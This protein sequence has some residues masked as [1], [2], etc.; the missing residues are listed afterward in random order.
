MNRKKSFKNHRTGSLFSRS[1]FTIL[2]AFLMAFT[3]VA[4]SIPAQ[5]ASGNMQITPIDYGSADNV[6]GDST[7]VSSGGKN[8]LMDTFIRDRYDTLINYLDDHHFYTFDIYLS[9]Y[10]WDHMDQISTI[11]ADSRFNVS[12]VYLPDPAYLRKGAQSSNYCQDLLDGHDDIVN[13]ANRCGCQVVYLKKGSSFTIGN[14]TANVLWGCSYSSSNYDAAYINNNSLVTKI[15]SGTVSYLTC[16]DIERE[17]ENQIVG[18]GINISADIFKFNHHGGNSSNT[19]A[20]VKK[21]NPSFAFEN[22]MEEDPSSFGGG[23]VQTAIDNLKNT[24]NIYSTRYNGML[25][26][27]VKAGHISVAGE[28]NM[29]SVNV[30]ITDASGNVVNTVNYQF[31]NALDYHITS[32]MK[33]T[34]ASVAADDAATALPERYASV[35]KF[36]ETSGGVK[37]RNKDGSYSTNKFQDIYGDTYYFDENGYRVTGFREINGK[38]YYFDSEGK[39]LLRWKRI[40]GKK[41]LFDPSDGHMHTGWEWVSEK[42]A[43]YYLSPDTGY[44]LEG[45]QFIGGKWYYLTPVDYYA[46]TG[47]QLIGGKWYFFDKSG[48]DMKTGWLTDGG[49]T[50]YLNKDG[51]M[52]TGT[53]NIDGRTYTFNSSG[54]L[55]GQAPSTASGSGT[56][57][58]TSSSGASG[59][60]T[61]WV[62][63]DGKWYYLQNGSQLKGCFRKIDGKTYYF[64]ENG[65]MLTGFSKIG[66]K[67]YYFDNSGSMLVGWKRIDGK[68]YFFDQTDGHMHTGWKWVSENST[69][70]YLSPDNGYLLEGWLDYGGKKYYLA[71]VDFYAMTGW[72]F[73]DGNWYYFDK[74]NADMK[75]GWLSDGGKTYYLN[76]D[77]VMVTGTQ[78]IDGRTY[79]F[80]SS[81]ALVG[82]AS[83]GSGTSA[84]TSSSSASGTT[85][86][87]VLTD[88]KWYY[89]QNGSQLKECFSKIGGKTYYFDENGVMLTG[90]GKIGGKT[91]CFDSSGS[92]LLG[93]KVIDGKKYF[94]DQTDGH[95]HTGW[96]WVSE[97]SAWYYLSPDYGYLLEGWLDYGGKKYYLTPADYDAKTGWQFIEGKWYF[98]DKTGCDMKTGWLSDGGKT[99]YL[100]EDGAMVTGSQTIDGKTYTFN[101]SGAMVGQTSSSAGTGLSGSYGNTTG[102]VLEDG[103]WF[104]LQNGAPIKNCFKKLGDSTYYLDENGVM[105]TGF[106][107]IG[108]KT[109]CFDTSGNMMLRWKR[110]DGKKYFFDPI[111]G[112]MHTGWEWVEE[113]KAWYYL[114]PDTGNLLEGWLTEGGRKYYLAPEEYYA[115]TGWQYIDDNWY[116]FDKTNAYMKTGWISDWGNS[117]YLREDGVMVTG[118]QTIEGETYTF[119]GSGALVGQ[120]PSGS[121]SSGNEDAVAGVSGKTLWN[122]ENYATSYVTGTWAASTDDDMPLDYTTKRNAAFVNTMLS[123]ATYFVDKIDYASSVTDNDPTGLRFLR[124]KSGGKTDCSW[125][126]YH[127]LYK[128]GL[129]GERFIHSY[130]WGNDPST[131]PGAVNIGTDMSKA[132]PGDIICTGRGTQSSNSHVMLYL[133]GNKVVECAAGYGVIIST[134]P[135]SPRQI[136]HFKC[137]PVNTSAPYKATTYGSWETSGSSWKFKVGGT[138]LTNRFQNIDGDIYYFGS[139]GLC[140]IG[141]KMIDGKW[142]YFQGGGQM[143]LRWK[144]ISGYKYYFDPISGYMHTGWEWVDEQNAWYYLDP[145]QGNM[146]TGWKTIDGQT[147]YFNSEGKML[148]G[149]Q[150]IDGSVYNFASSGALQN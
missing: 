121:T 80:N 75:T 52:V 16:G 45:W 117:Y 85:T 101:S 58:G 2:L 6:W 37:Y 138:Y 36:I 84:G 91:Y 46:K 14:A 96:K 125:F 67:T 42:N 39:M 34:A 9:H 19:A 74:T 55:V 31:N 106:Q 29:N 126:V 57:S 109:Y 61:G 27:T 5:A 51:A 136:V 148:T 143:Y 43:W 105:L 145:S 149:T 97:K 144:R 112:H 69:W 133:G 40:D 33:S 122:S 146:V 118:S 111:D 89:L 94:F 83:S 129:A 60:K 48:C 115:M 35:A 128:F 95:M 92:M 21:V 7:M 12:K 70:Y 142:Y 88:G 59:T 38:T 50:Y 8:L 108:D 135:S 71:P 93:W 26:F 30:E 23:W 10:H 99:Y 98:F 32:A 63:T 130:E 4:P 53:Q 65:V 104:Y 82:Q 114:S 140:A 137:L 20:F 15:T 73:I 3:S 44:L 139:D 107:K 22:C 124:L 103:R 54:A 77:G 123:Y 47:W 49:K 24:C 100:N 81:G 78:N 11:I 28:R 113:N 62:L 147:Y 79:T 66:D 56:S 76:K 102:W 64:D 87:W 13:T 131:Y 25:T 68:K 18:S 86:G 120:A 116:Y 150:T 17:T 132:S 90:L 41:Y 141:W 1:F 72:Q 134:A 110:I 127:V 119:N